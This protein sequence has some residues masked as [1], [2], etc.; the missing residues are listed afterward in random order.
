MATLLV[1]A[2]P[3]KPLLPVTL[4][5]RYF[6]AGHERVSLPSNHDSYTIFKLSLGYLL[7]I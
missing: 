6:Y 7:T 4:V 5:G 1:Q 3:M 2:Q